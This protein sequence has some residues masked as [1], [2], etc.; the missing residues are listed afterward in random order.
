M[1]YKMLRVNFGVD[2]IFLQRY[3]LYRLPSA[4]FCIKLRRGSFM[5]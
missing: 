1:N 4:Y 5:S 3:L 2:L